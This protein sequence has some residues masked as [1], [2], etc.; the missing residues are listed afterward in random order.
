MDNG[1]LVPLFALVTTPKMSV[2]QPYFYA[3][4]AVLYINL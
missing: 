3:I 1:I 2:V 4:S